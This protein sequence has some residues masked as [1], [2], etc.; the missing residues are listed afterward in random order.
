MD[1]EKSI[2]DPVHGYI[3]IPREYCRLFVD[4]PIF[5]RLRL[6]E[7]TSMRWLFPGARHDRFIHSLGVYHLAKRIFDAL[8]KNVQ[9]KEVKAILTDT[10]GLKSTFLVAAL[11][12]DCGHSPFSH[13]LEKFYNKCA[14]EIAHERAF[15]ALKKVAPQKDRD[16]LDF[17]KIGG[18][19]PAHHEAMSAFVLLSQY[20]EAMV[21]AGVDSGLAARMITGAAY[22]RP[23]NIREKV[24]NVLIELVNGSAL[25]VD[26]L[27]YIIR[28]TWASGVKNTAIDVDRLVHGA[29]IVREHKLNGDD[30]IHFAFKKSSISVVQ[31]VIDARNYLYDW[32]YGHHTVLYYSHL[33]EMAVVSFARQ[34]A[35]ANHTTTNAVLQRMFSPEMF[36]QRMPLAKTGGLKAYLLSDGDILHCLKMFVPDDPNYVSYLSHKPR[37]VPLWKTG[38]EYRKNVDA[39]H[40]F[41]VKA[42][43]C[44]SKIRRQFKL[45]ADECFA[46]SDMTMK[47]YD[48]KDDSVK[49]EISN[50]EVLPITAVTHLPKH[51]HLTSGMTE[52]LFYIYLANEK[53][54]LKKQIIDFIN[55]MDVCKLDY[56]TCRYA[57]NGKV[58]DARNHKSCHRFRRH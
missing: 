53:Q 49:I 44:I 2:K 21:G 42:D 52:S 3:T 46:C 13:T 17:T 24:A 1:G 11:M 58:C 47:I 29:T 45:S 19:H 27:D 26:K 57:P 20:T 9:D 32:I 5:Q 34:Y 39:K 51:P 6:I 36:S 31:S 14:D 25:D 15:K 38:V 16:D 55:K 8:G 4:T 12:H 48:L 30:A 18:K 50:N 41:S 37:H 35:K 40:Q 23:D 7:Q 56:C 28:D 10:S 22:K 54:S 43:V 33:I